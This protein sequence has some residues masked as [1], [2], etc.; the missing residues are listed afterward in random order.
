MTEKLRRI[1]TRQSETRERLNVL[2]GKDSRT[3]AEQTELTELRNKATEIE[4]ELR[5]A[6]AESETDATTETRETES[7]DAEERERRELRRRASLHPYINGAILGTAVEGAEAE[8]AAAMGCPGMVPL[9]ML[10]GTMEERQREHR[11]REHRAVTPAPADADV[12]HSHAPIVPALFDRSVAPFLGIE[13]PTVGTGI[14]SYP[15]L[16]TNVTGGM[17]AEDGDAAN[18]A[19]ASRS[20]TRTRGGSRARSR[21]AKRTSR[22]CR[23]SRSR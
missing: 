13:M 23:T 1:L 17:K 12:P 16:S 2:A 11:E 3:D 15:V 19:G 7:I 14:R 18:T 21:S 8:Y 10:G 6:L 9:A 5:E 22:S 4:T 20:R